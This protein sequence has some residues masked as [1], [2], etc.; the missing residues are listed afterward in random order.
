MK[1]PVRV[2][3][4]GVGHLGNYHA[5]KIDLIPN[6]ELSFICDQSSERL[7]ELEKT[8]KCQTEYDFKEL[9]GKVDA[10]VI[11]TPT[12]HHFEVA[13][14]FLSHGVH[15]FIEKPMTETVEQAEKLCELAHANNLKLQIGHVE[16]F[17]P[18]LLSA[19]KKLNEPLFI[20]CTRIAP[21]KPRSMDVDVVLDL[22][23]HD[24]DVVL[25]LTKSKVVS[26][27]AVG[28]PVLTP[29]V[30][31]ANARIEFES[32]AVANITA[33]RVSQKSERKFRVFQQQQYLSIDFG[34]SELN[35]TT[36]TGEW[37]NFDEELPLEFDSWSLDKGDALLAEDQAFIDSI[38]NGEE[39]V[40]TGEQG[41]K[42]LKVAEQI[43]DDI[44]RRLQ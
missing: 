29:H 9:K 26:V 14:F 24:I 39:P 28:T 15:V 33:S 35:L 32:K 23:I 41:L 25:S 19:R 17:N 11:A 1:S 43:R 38:L 44:A 21:F 22:M 20:E 34:T 7:T 8:Y 37:S 6:A 42:A 2:G 5:Q 36:K 16:R 10:V 30:D 40:V 12:K 31:I 18:A 27:S 4:V 13:S 3:V